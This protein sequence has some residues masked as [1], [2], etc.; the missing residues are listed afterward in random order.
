VLIMGDFL[1]SHTSEIV[2]LREPSFPSLPE[3]TWAVTGARGRRGIT[4]SPLGPSEKLSTDV[5]ATLGA[6][7]A[8]HDAI[9]AEEVR[10]ETGGLDD[11]EVVVVAFGFAGRFVKYAVRLAREHGLRIGFVRPISL[12]PFP[13]EAVAQAAAHA[14]TVAVFE[15]NAGQMVEDV[16]LAVR[17]RTPVVSIGGISHDHSGFGVGPL[18]NVDY[19]LERLVQVYEGR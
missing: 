15:L 7:T 9:K 13:R 4:L 12:W 3:K 11:A 18:L 5:A 6:V 19:I 16:E 14:R 1:L 8:K 10:A 17:G 2:A